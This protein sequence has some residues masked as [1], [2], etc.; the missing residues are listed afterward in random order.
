MQCGKLRHLLSRRSAQWYD[1]L[2]LVCNSKLIIGSM[3]CSYNHL[4]LLSTV[5]M[6]PVESTHVDDESLLKTMLTMDDFLK[7]ICLHGDVIRLLA[8]PTERITPGLLAAFMPSRYM[9]GVAL[10]SSIL[11]PTCI[12]WNVLDKVQ[13]RRVTM[14][15]AARTRALDE[16][17]RNHRV[18]YIKNRECELEEAVIWLANRIH[19]MLAC[20]IVNDRAMMELVRAYNVIKEPAINQFK[21]YRGIEHVLELFAPHICAAVPR[22]INAERI[23]PWHSCKQ[24]APS[25]SVQT[26][27]NMLRAL[28]L[29]VAIYKSWYDGFR[30]VRSLFLTPNESDGVFSVVDFGSLFF[31]DQLLNVLVECERANGVFHFDTNLMLAGRGFPGTIVPQCKNGRPTTCVTWITEGINGVATVPA[32]K[33]VA[34]VAALLLPAC[35]MTSMARTGQYAE[36]TQVMWDADKSVL[37]QFC[38]GELGHSWL[39]G[40]VRDRMWLHATFNMT[41]PP[42]DVSASFMSSVVCY[43]TD[44]Y[45]AKCV[46]E[47]AVNE[48]FF[49]WGQTSL[50]PWPYSMLSDAS[51]VSF[52]LTGLLRRL[53][54]CFK[55]MHALH[56]G[57]F[58]DLSLLSVFYI[59][60]LFSVLGACFRANERVGTT[61]ASED[62]YCIAPLLWNLGLLTYPFSATPYFAGDEDEVIHFDS[63]ARHFMAVCDHEGV[64][65]FGPGFDLGHFEL[66]NV[67]FDIGRL[68]LYIQSPRIQLAWLASQQ[69]WR[70]FTSHIAERGDSLVSPFSCR[71]NVFLP[72]QIG[73]ESNDYSESARIQSLMRLFPQDRTLTLRLCLATPAMVAKADLSSLC[74]PRK[75]AHALARC[76]GSRIQ[77]FSLVLSKWTNVFQGAPLPNELRHLI[78]LCYIVDVI[79]KDNA[80][81]ILV[82]HPSATGTMP[83]FY[84]C[85]TS[86]AKQAEFLTDYILDQ[87]MV[88]F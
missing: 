70:T 12:V 40:D 11:R 58:T 69:Q 52:T 6:T 15:W 55:W 26:I 44:L 57:G 31:I 56:Y 1:S 66:P 75:M 79:K 7:A 22:R 78:L 87:P 76:Y 21:S 10:F 37:P 39:Y 60:D 2:T 77:I 86:V 19:L 43:M 13:K 34:S 84:A 48:L 46:S 51:Q 72:D 42:L 36:W 23:W 82:R 45:L 20:A 83:S 8:M 64:Y 30:I 63:N 33:L 38:L 24:H 50:Q 80:R 85:I 14:A 81:C 25:C 18:A 4:C 53:V 32:A 59:P 73:Q 61:I 35:V 41:T 71:G 54:F 29:D 9:L 49:G 28:F 62:G 16:Y 68:L 27:L 5:P 88:F 74:D 3:C 47:K 17:H 65:S 67:G